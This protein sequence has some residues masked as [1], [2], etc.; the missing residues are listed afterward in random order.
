MN[1]NIKVMSV[2]KDDKNL[3]YDDITE[4][5]KNKMNLDENNELIK[6]RRS[7]VDR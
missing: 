4:F 1:Q 3:T 2:V 7:V 6:L 5:L